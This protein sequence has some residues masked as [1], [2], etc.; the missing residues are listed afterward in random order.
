MSFGALIVK[1]NTVSIGAFANVDVSISLDGLLVR[2]DIR[3]IF[4]ESSEV[5]SPYEASQI[6]FKPAVSVQDSDFSGITSANVL[7]I[8]GKD[9]RFDGKPRPDGNGFTLIYLQV[10]K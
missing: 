3:G 8:R 1:C 5:V 2:D 10:K 4:D 6:V 9:Y 7:T